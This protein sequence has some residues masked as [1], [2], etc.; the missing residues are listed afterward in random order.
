MEL[1]A[2]YAKWKSQIIKSQKRESKI[3]TNKNLTD[4]KG[5]NIGTYATN[6]LT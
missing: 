6:K 4:Q 3:E 2:K 5:Q 1:V